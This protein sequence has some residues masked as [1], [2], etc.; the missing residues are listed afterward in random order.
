MATVIDRENSREPF[1]KAKLLLFLLKHSH[2]LNLSHQSDIVG[3]IEKLLPEE[4]EVDVLLEL[5]AELIA[6]LVT[7]HPDYS[8]LAGRVESAR[9]RRNAHPSFTENCKR[10][11]LYV[12]PKTKKPFPLLSEA[13]MSFVANNLDL[14][15]ELARSVDIDLAYFGIKTLTKSYLLKLGSLPSE[16]VE[17]LFLRVAIG[18]HGSTNENA[19]ELVRQTF[20]LMSSKYFIHSSPTLFHA[21]TENNY[22]SSCFLLAMED[23]SISGIYKTLYKAALISKGSG[24]IGLHVHNIRSTGSL[25]A[26][27]NGT[28]SG[29]VPMLRVFNDTARY[30]DQGGNKRPGAIAIYL[31]PWHADIFSVLNLRKNHGSEELRARDLFYALWIPDLFMKR[32]K[33]DGNWSLFSPNEAPGLNEVYG[34]DFEELYTKYEGQGLAVQTTNAQKL[35]MLILEAQIETGMPFML[36]KDACNKKLNQQ[37]LGTIQSSNLC[38]EIVEY[39]DANETAVCNLASLGLPSFIERGD[40]LKYDF[41]KLH[42]VT[43]I[44]TRNLDRVIDVTKYPID[45]A[46]DSNMKNRPIAI[47]VQGL[48]DVFMELRLPFELAE[49]RKLNSQIFET[50]YHAAVEAL[51]ELA[52]EFGPYATF[53]GSPASKGVLQFDMWGVKPAFF[54]DWNDLKFNVQKFGLRNSLLVAPMPTASTS[55]ILGFSE[56][57]EPYTLNIFLRRVLAGEY[58]IVNRFLLRDLIDLKIWSPVLKDQILVDNGLIQSIAIIPDEIKRLYK[59]VWEIPQ[60]VIVDMAADRGAYIDQLQSMNINMKEPTFSKLTSC[61]FYAWRKG[62]KTGMYYLRSQAASRA[63]QFTVDKRKLEELEVAEKPQMTLLRAPPYVGAT[64]FE[65]NK[66]KLKG[67]FS[68]EILSDDETLFEHFDV[69]QRKSDTNTPLSCTPD[70]QACDSCSG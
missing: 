3:K 7:H 44:V 30:V 48:A 64:S 24:G 5:S 40:V 52:R 41:D 16:T 31:E 27:L 46:R 65:P 43:K 54:H 56:C 21:G 57:F 26:S 28:S 25:I 1:S 15:D 66:K 59:T 12:H 29:L 50:I 69:H 42:E 37:N 61:H 2:G 33:D 63:I 17:Y 70:N 35:W 10:L 34:D 11:R 49:A 6:Q 32:V 38:C 19:M 60:K 58:Q 39:L 22:L 53:E 14:L 51:V 9:L 67:N 23:D 8:Q 18:I 20:E 13:T 55:L 68:H 4:V 47:G 62:L 36:Y 45:S